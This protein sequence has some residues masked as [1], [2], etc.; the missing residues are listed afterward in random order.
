MSTTPIRAPSPPSSALIHRH[1]DEGDYSDETLGGTGSRSSSGSRPGSSA[2]GHVRHS[3]FFPPTPPYSN[4][5]RPPR[6]PTEYHH[7][8][9]HQYAPQYPP[10]PSSSTSGRRPN[11]HHRPPP[12]TTIPRSAYAASHS[13]AHSRRLSGY[14]HDPG[15]ALE[16]QLE[17]QHQYYDDM[18]LGPE[19]PPSPHASSGGGFAGADPHENLAAIVDRAGGAVSSLS[20]SIP[21]LHQLCERHRA[22]TAELEHYER[23]VAEQEGQMKELLSK[24]KKLDQL[25]KTMEHLSGVHTAE[26]N[27][28]RNRIGDLEREIK[29]LQEA[30]EKKE[31]ERESFEVKVDEEKEELEKL[32]DEWK[33]ETQEEHEKAL[34]ELK[35]EQEKLLEEERTKHEGVLGEKDAEHSKAFEEKE[36][37]HQVSLKDCEDA[38]EAKTK[39]LEE[40]FKQQKAE[41]VSTHESKLADAESAHQA[42]IEELKSAQMKQ[43]EDFAT[44][45]TSL[46]E[47]FLAEKAKLVEEFE[48]ETRTIEEKFN[49]VKGQVEEAHANEKKRIEAAFA[50]DLEA[51]EKTYSEEK[52]AL[53]ERFAAERTAKEEAFAKE[54]ED[55]KAE[56]YKEKEEMNSVF[57]AEKADIEA[58]FEKE[59]AKLHE[60]FEAA[61]AAWA[62]EKER[63][64]SGWEAEK[65][66][67][68]T[69]FANEKAQLEEIQ[70]GLE[71]DKENL[72]A[73]TIALKG[74]KE[75]LQTEKAA[76]ESLR[77]QLEERVSSLETLKTSLEAEK[78]ALVAVGESKAAEYSAER[79]RL[80]G[81]IANLQTT[82]D[83]MQKEN[84][85]LL[86]TLKKMAEEE[87]GG[88]IRSRGDGFYIDAFTKLTKDIV[89]LSHEFNTLPIAPP[90]RVLAELP[91]GLPSMLNDTEASKLLRQAYVQHTI[92]KYLCYRI[93][94]PFLFSL[95]KRYDKADTFFQAMSNQLREKST[96]KEAVWRHYTLLAGYTTSNA[97]KNQ[98][99]A[100]A[101]VIEEIAAYIKPFA[102]PKKMNVVT[103]GI[104][105]IV[106]F[107]IETWRYAR[108]EREIVTASMSTDDATDPE[109]WTSHAWDMSPLPTSPSKEEGGNSV[110]MTL[111]PVFMREGTLPSLH[112]PNAVLDQGL[113]FSKGVALY[114]DCAPVLQR[115]HELGSLEIDIDDIE[116]V[117]EHV[118]A[119][120]NT[121]LEKQARE[122][123]AR[124]MAGNEAQGPPLETAEQVTDEEAAAVEAAIEAAV[125]K[126]MHRPVESVIGGVEIPKGELDCH[127]DA[128]AALVEVC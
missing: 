71:T 75:T 35:E 108:M 10:A 17:R 101:Q 111:L 115:K 114:A 23:V 39:A 125:E 69:G 123:L 6:A 117:P 5:S 80:D 9:Q 98:Q 13:G 26:V 92:S 96:R 58:A 14:S 93:F 83:G 116:E 1:E 68:T 59:R 124:T 81:I 15:L 34:R 22:V 61:K 65:E 127:H 118:E 33:R 64:L 19:Y 60:T 67:M 112:R 102:D 24:E 79:A 94:Q 90:S 8:Q 74:E 62:E 4:H 27:T 100:A 110:V 99:V 32:F 7:H 48:A 95:G 49:A 20:L 120:E 18:I 25:K 37:A 103:S 31:R 42:K 11:Y 128:A 109:R 41:L 70:K 72:T 38:H 107:A 21:S 16:M 57:T 73:D 113:V 40:D 50:E 53:E 2:G 45:K 88:E 54:K 3:S 97:K 122:D 51:K 36:A 44:E 47:T 82:L 85:K 91:A 43:A 106:K 46:N 105:R 66:N 119:R 84:K 126:H 12:P 87:E 56:F 28:L 30:I 78:D 104:T 77:D 121:E 76:L 52:Q 89:D 63:M 86:D 55:M 29:R